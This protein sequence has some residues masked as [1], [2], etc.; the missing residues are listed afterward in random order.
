MLI[1]FDVDGT[2]AVFQRSAWSGAAVLHVGDEVFKVASPFR[3]STQFSLSNVKAW[4]VRV[5]D[6]DI[7]IVK[8]RSRMHML[9]T[10][11]LLDAAYTVRVD[12]QVV[13][14]A[15]GP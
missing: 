14:E 7:E 8:R 4:T 3:L 9:M 15:D 5:G 1:A 10:G 13:A 6:H 11:G 12:G 2:L